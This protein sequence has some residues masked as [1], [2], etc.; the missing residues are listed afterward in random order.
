MMYD[1]HTAYCGVPDEIKRQQSEVLVC[2]HCGNKAP[3]QVLHQHSDLEALAYGNQLASP[4]EGYIFEWLRC[5]SC[6]EMVLRRF[7]WIDGYEMRSDDIR[8]IAIYPIGEG[9]CRGLPPKIMSSYRAAEKVKGI[10]ANAYGVL[11]GRVL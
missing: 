6:R 3:M 8:P 7:H 9:R 11:I 2:A 4:F 10:D 5:H 1:E